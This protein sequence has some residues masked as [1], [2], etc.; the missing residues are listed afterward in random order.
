MAIEIQYA[1]SRSK[2]ERNTRSSSASTTT[3][4]VTAKVG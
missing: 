3:A 2:P 4:A 1:G